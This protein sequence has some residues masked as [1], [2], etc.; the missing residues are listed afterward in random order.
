LRAID[1]GL[2]FERARFAAAFSSSR[3]ETLGC[4]RSSL[5]H[6]GGS[7]PGLLAAA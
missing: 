3:A 7:A 1:Q 6:S 5:A 2:R 4:L